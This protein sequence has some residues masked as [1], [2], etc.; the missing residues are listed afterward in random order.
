[1]K[2]NKK[3]LIFFGIIFL[4]IVL[5]SLA[6]Y[7]K[8]NYD[9]NQASYQ[10]GQGLT[11]EQKKSNINNLVKKHNYDDAKTL[12]DNYY[13]YDNDVDK[14]L[15]YSLAIQVCK[16]KNLDSLDKAEIKQYNNKNTNKDTST[17]K[18]Q[19]NENQK[20]NDKFI[21]IIDSIQMLLFILFIIFAIT[22]FIKLMKYNIYKENIGIYI[23]SLIIPLVGF[24][25]G[26]INLTKDTPYKKSTGMHCIVLAVI[27]C[28]FGYLII[29]K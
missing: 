27:S 6:T 11:D 24:I 20:V 26:S 16:E 4:L 13:Y 5:I 10:T 12:A 23:V 25:I 29:S 22:Q 15:E 3:T 9:L 8:Y 14:H 17:K 21:K 28:I 7:L 2:I 1:M 18:E 19:S